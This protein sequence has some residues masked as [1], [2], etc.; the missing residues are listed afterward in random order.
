MEQA[1]ELMLIATTGKPLPEGLQIRDLPPNR[2]QGGTMYLIRTDDP[3]RKDP[4]TGLCTDGYN[5]VE[6]LH[7]AELA[8]TRGNNIDY[9]LATDWRFSF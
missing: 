6:I 8:T 7:Q 3:S 9:R 1:E 4:V 2:P 5:W